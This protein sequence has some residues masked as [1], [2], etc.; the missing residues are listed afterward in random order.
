MSKSL[1]IYFSHIGEN[2][3]NGEIKDINK[4]NTEVVAEKISQMTWKD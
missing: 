3:I 2:Y 1:V 4:G